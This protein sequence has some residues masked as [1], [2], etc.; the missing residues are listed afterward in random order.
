MTRDEFFAL[1]IEEAFAELAHQFRA[2]RATVGKWLTDNR[3]VMWTAA[4]YGVRMLADN[5]EVKILEGL[6]EALLLGHTCATCAWCNAAKDERP[7][8]C[9]LDQPSYPHP[10]ERWE[11]ADSR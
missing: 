2:D 9:V 8:C 6:R 5:G 1:P 4:E 11:D 3:D 7:D 10:C